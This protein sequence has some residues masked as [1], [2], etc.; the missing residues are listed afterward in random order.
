M[1]PLS[2]EEERIL[3]HKGT[4]A[5]FT[6]AYTEESRPGTYLCRQC[7]TALYRSE[8]KFASGCGWPSFEDALPGTVRETLDADGRRVE[9]TC[10]T[11]GGHLG[12]V[13]RGEGMTPKN[14]RF[15]VNSASLVFVPKAEPSLQHV[16]LGGGCFWCLEDTL[17]Q[18]RG[19]HDVVSGYAGGTTEH[20]TYAQVSTG[21]TGHREVVRVTFN[22][23]EI[24]FSDLLAVFFTLHDPTTPGRQGNDVGD[25]YSSVIYTES[26]EQRVQAMDYIRGLEDRGEWSTP[27]VTEVRMLSTFWPAEEYHQRYR[28]KNPDQAYCRLVIDPKRAKLRQKWSHLLKN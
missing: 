12:H 1:P 2:P 15:C 11:C 24:R 8:D 7:G 23:S 28:E 21:Q 13:F 19:I 14:T 17:R 22:P 4:E 27:V 5:P 3:I 26:E 6:G 25:Q 16:L 9:I 20:P 18:L 10:M